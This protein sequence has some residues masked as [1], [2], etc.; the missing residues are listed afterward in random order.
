MSVVSLPTNVSVDTGNVKVISLANV[1]S[2]INVVLLVPLL[3]SSNNSIKPA[4]V[5]PFLTVIPASNIS[6][7][8]WVTT[9]LNVGVPDNVPENAAPLIFGVVNVL[10]VNVSVVSLATSMSVVSCIVNVLLELG[11]NEAITGVVSVLFVNVSIV[12][13]P[14]NVS[15]VIGKV[16]TRSTLL[17]SAWPINVVL[18]APKSE[19]S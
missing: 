3:L 11:F 7:A 15:V 13:L 9:W 8:L 2:P 18:W 14:T 12:S 6:N 1:S 4:D 5:D 19:S 17:V 16:I 10:L